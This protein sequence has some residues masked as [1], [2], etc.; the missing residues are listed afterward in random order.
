MNFSKINLLLTGIV[1]VSGVTLLMSTPAEAALTASEQTHCYALGK[2][3][4]DL[5]DVENQAV[6]IV[7]DNM[8]ANAS[9]KDKK[10]L[11]DLEDMAKTTGDIGNAL[12]RVYASAPAPAQSE[13]DALQKVPM[14]QLVSQVEKCANG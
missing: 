6:K 5:A 3:F 9:D 12:V 7:K 13:L 2:T 4:I 8:A 10:D 14:D 1:A 11:A